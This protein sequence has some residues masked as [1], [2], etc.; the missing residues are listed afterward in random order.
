MP[1]NKDLTGM[2]VNCTEHRRKNEMKWKK[3]INFWNNSFLALIYSL[4]AAIPVRS[5]NLNIR[6][7][8]LMQLAAMKLLP[9]PSPKS[10]KMGHT[11]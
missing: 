8:Q 11:L 6:A 10:A 5:N 2:G 9:A 3:Y 1:Y 7:F 4:K